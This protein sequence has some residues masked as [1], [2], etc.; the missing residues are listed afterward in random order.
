MGVGISILIITCHRSLVPPIPLSRMCLSSPFNFF[1]LANPNLASK[2]WRQGAAPLWNFSMEIIGLTKHFM[3]PWLQLNLYTLLPSHHLIIY[4]GESS[5]SSL[6]RN[7]IV[8]VPKNSMHWPPITP[9][10]TSQLLGLAVA[11]S[12]GPSSF[13]PHVPGSQPPFPHNNPDK[14]VFLLLLE[15]AMLLFFDL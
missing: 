7:W 13:W 4:Y 6:K 11:P 8:S 12:P 10:R 15:Q 2:R 14:P 3:Y 1:S 5:Q 9:D